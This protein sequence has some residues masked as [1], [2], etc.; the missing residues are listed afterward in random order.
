MRE[1]G[2][3]ADETDHDLPAVGTP[4]QKDV[5]HQPLAGLLIV[6][7]NALLPEEP[8]Q[9]RADIVEHRGLQFAIRAGNDPMGPSGVETDAG[10]AVL[11]PPHRELHLVAVAV[12]LRGRLDGQ[13]RNIQPADAGKGVCN[14]FLLGTQLRP[15][16]QMPQ[17]AAAAGT[18]Y[19]AVQRDAVGGGGQDLVQNTKGVTP[20]VFYDAHLC[21][22]AGGGT[23]NKNSFAVGAVRH[24]AAIAGKALDLQGQD[25][26]FL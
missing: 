19:G 23:G 21:L 12:H 7:L 2:T 26:V 5:P 1:F 17:A 14:V 24:T 6:G 11:I 3:G 9:R 4:A 16:I 22:I 8:T 13:Y 20:A 10:V 15:V 18:G 25:L